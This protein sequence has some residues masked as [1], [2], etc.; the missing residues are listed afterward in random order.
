MNRTSR[1]V[2][3]RL[4]GTVMFGCV[5]AGCRK[6]VEVVSPPDI[7]AV[8]AIVPRDMNGDG[9]INDK[10][11]S[12]IAQHAGDPALQLNFVRAPL[13]DR[14]LLQ[15]KKFPNLRRIAAVGSPITDK[16]I[17]ELKAAIPEVQIIK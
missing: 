14:G 16:G 5:L 3:R 8:V 17:A 4:I 6:T 12:E 1:T 10:A 13:S 11:L 15:L 7:K 9:T 2:L